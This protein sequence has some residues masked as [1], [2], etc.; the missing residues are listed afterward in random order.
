MADEQSD[1]EKEALNAWLQNNVGESYTEAFKIR[2]VMYR[3]QDMD[4]PFRRGIRTEQ[5]ITFFVVLI[6]L[7][8]LWAIVVSPLLGAAGI[9]LPW[10]FI[11]L[12]FLIPPFLL[13]S[14]MG[15]PMP[16]QKSIQGTI[17]SFLRD[18]LD[19]KWHCRGMPHKGEIE[20]EYEGNY[21]RTWTV[22][23]KYVGLES[24]R[25]QPAVEFEHPDE[26]VFPDRKV[27]FDTGLKRR[28]VVETDDEFN[29]RIMGGISGGDTQQQKDSN[30]VGL[31]NVITTS[32]SAE[33]IEDLQNEPVLTLDR[34]RIKS[35]QQDAENEND[36]ELHL[37]DKR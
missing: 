7:F 11:A 13:S 33:M 35:N 4:L 23:P 3:I 22:D 31:T 14:R 26:H 20:P 15:K 8:I 36:G 25:E 29:E 18:F 34:D 10:T 21:M 32:P 24:D 6:I 28:R 27:K 16:Y 30:R 37:I 2:K 19:D 9:S 5:F 17:I 1:V 12:Y